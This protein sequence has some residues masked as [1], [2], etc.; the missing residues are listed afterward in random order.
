MSD[1]NCALGI[2][3]L[4]RLDEFVVKRRRVAG[5]YQE[6]LGDD[7]RLI[8]PTE[9]AGC[10][11][12]WFVFVVRLA[13]RYTQ[14]DRDAVLDEMRNRGIQVSNYFPPVHLQPFMVEQFGYSKGDFE[15]TEAV[16]KS[17]IALPFYNN[18][19]QEQAE[20]VSNELKDVLD[21]IL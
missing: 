13:D 3:Q 18:L 4:S 7:D 6:M 10:D 12:S 14:A 5:Y 1:I 9:P 19:A 15:I 21:K 20:I 11:M 17:T 16:C 2:V 8:I